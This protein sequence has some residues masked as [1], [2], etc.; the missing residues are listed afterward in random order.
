M[1]DDLEFG[2]G[3]G[4]LLAVLRDAD[5]G[6][7]DAPAGVAEQFVRD[8][9]LQVA[10][11]GGV[12]CGELVVGLGFAD[13]KGDGD[14]AAGAHGDAHP[15]GDQAALG[16]GRIEVGGGGRVEVL[17]RGAGKEGG[18]ELG[19]FGPGALAGDGGV[20]E[21]DLEVEV[22]LEGAGAALFKGEFDG[23][24]P[25]E[26]GHHGA[27]LFF[28]GLGW[29]FAAVLVE[30]TG[31]QF[32]QTRKGDGAGAVFIRLGEGVVDRAARAGGQR[33]ER[34]RDEPGRGGVC[35]GG[36]MRVA[37]GHGGCRQGG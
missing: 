2:L 3:L 28:G 8:G 7:V 37:G 11:V 20:D 10:V 30:R 17:P 19:F 13:R 29:A 25:G 16:L 23:F 1:T 5:R 34:E 24:E 9:E 36:A 21:R 12:E 6:G 15:G 33:E 35:E 32:A 26:A 14:V 27:G 31:A 4:D 18:L 22:A